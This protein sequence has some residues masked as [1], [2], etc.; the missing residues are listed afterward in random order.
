MLCTEKG[1]Q[2]NLAMT[3]LPWT[4]RTAG[5]GAHLL[6]PQG[7]HVIAAVGGGAT[8]MVTTKRREQAPSPPCVHS[9]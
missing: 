3:S 7:P 6:Q 5:L 1:D 2:V 8:A 9:H 4:V